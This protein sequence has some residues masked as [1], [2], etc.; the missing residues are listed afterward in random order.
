MPKFRETRVSLLYVH[1][2]GLLD[3]V[4]F[5]LLY[6]VTQQKNLICL[7][8]SMMNLILTKCLTT[9]VRL[10]FGFIEVIYTP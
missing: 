5:L 4:E 9:N 1:D 6:D 3:D 2:A 7:I 10:N 8:G